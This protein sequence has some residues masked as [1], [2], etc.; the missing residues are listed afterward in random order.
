[1][2]NSYPNPWDFSNKD[3]NLVSPDG[4]YRIEYGGLSEISMGAPVGGECFLVGPDN[5]KVKLSDWAGGPVVWETQGSRVAF[6]VWTTT[7]DQK[8]AIADTNLRMLTIYSQT[9]RVLDFKTF[10]KGI[11][12][13]QDSPI[14]MTTN[15]QFDTAKE[16][17]EKVK[18]F[19]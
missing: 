7:R 14:H 1:M 3:K 5:S 10:E 2:T 16:M 15:I 8:I 13:G 17:I 18:K 4:Q 12:T 9:F 19:K 6:P 11:I